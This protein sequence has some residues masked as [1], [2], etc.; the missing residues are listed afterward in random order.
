MRTNFSQYF[1]S[2]RGPNL[3]DKRVISIKLTFSDSDSRQAFKHK[4]KRFPLS[5]ELNNLEIFK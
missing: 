5:V 1:I 4:L 2:Y 3:W